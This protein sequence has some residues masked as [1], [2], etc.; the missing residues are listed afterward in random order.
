MCT[1]SM[2]SLFATHEFDRVSLTGF[3]TSCTWGVEG[4][5]GG[6]MGSAGLGR[7]GRIS[8]DRMRRGVADIPRALAA[9]DA[10]GVAHCG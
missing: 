10:V 9:V 3:P 2:L 5:G 6:L 1:Y 8:R 7:A 4:V